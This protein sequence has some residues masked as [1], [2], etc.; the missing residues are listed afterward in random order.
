MPSHESGRRGRVLLWVVW[1]AGGVAAVCLAVAGCRPAS[2]G[3]DAPA[4]AVVPAGEGHEADTPSFGPPPVSADRLSE[5]EQ[6]MRSFVTGRPDLSAPP[7]AQRDAMVRDSLAIYFTPVG[8]K[9]SDAKGLLVALN[10]E[11][12]LM[13]FSLGPRQLERFLEGKRR[14]KETGAELVDMLDWRFGTIEVDDGGA[15]GGNTTEMTHLLRY[16]F[17]RLDWWP[18]D[19]AEPGPMV[20][21]EGRLPWGRVDAHPRLCYYVLA[22]ESKRL[23]YVMGW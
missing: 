20:A 10:A 1:A 5:F 17:V 16:P 4:S 13:R 6:R 8:L 12:L 3:D 23:L 14:L 15:F 19:E 7:C 9:V 22:D 21:Y 11:G 2:T 18:P